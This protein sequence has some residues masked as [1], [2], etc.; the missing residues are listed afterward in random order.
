MFQTV[1]SRVAIAVGLYGAPLLGLP[2]VALPRFMG[3]AFFANPT[4]ASGL[5]WTV[6]I[7]IGI[8]W[9]A[10]YTVMRRST[11]PWRAAVLTAALNW[12]ACSLLVLPTAGLWGP[13]VA[14]GLVAAPG[15]M[16]LRWS[17]DAPWTLLLAFGLS[18]PVFALS[19]AHQADEATTH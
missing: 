4:W 6:F 8:I 14:S 2:E 12:V 7:V 18:V 11:G 13:R 1:G 16:G 3:E 19:S 9:T 15:W 17:P 5:G 10:L